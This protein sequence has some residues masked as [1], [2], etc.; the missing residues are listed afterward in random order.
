MI[1]ANPATLATPIGPFRHYTIAPDDHRLVYISGQ[2]GQDENG[3]L[4]SGGV[5]GQTAQVF[6]NFELI[7]EDLGVGPHHIVKLFTVLAGK[8]S[9]AEFA[10]ARTEVFARW[11]PDGDYPAHSAF[12]A[13]ELAG[14]DLKVEIEAVVAVP[15]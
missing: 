11:Y 8:G 4:V 1:G 7:L 2:V 5:G 12:V 14:P 13:A 10:A 9:F 15:R 6:R 3:E